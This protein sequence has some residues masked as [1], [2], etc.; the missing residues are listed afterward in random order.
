MRLLLDLA[1]ST[2][3]SRRRRA[4]CQAELLQYAK[5]VD[6]A[7][8][9]CHLPVFESH[10]VCFTPS[11]RPAGWRCTGERSE[12]CASR[13][14]V[15]HDQITLG[16]L[17]LDFVAQVGESRPHSLNGI[18]QAC[19]SI[20]PGG[21]RGLPVVSKRWRGQLV[22]ERKIA[23]GE[24]LKRNSVRGRSVLVHWASPVVLRGTRGSGSRRAILRDS[25]TRCLAGLSA[26]DFCAGCILY[27]RCAMAAA[28]ALGIQKRGLPVADPPPRRRCPNQMHL[29]PLPGLG[30][31]LTRPSTRTHNCVRA[32]RAR[33]SCAP[34][35]SDVRQ[36]QLTMRIGN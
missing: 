12:V 4:G 1:P 20:G 27:S 30:L 16:E 10:H 26:P 22:E 28:F 29:A 24:E 17:V 3:A 13:G 8:L 18:C 11:S 2:S 23:T 6:D 25:R 35:K 36:R 31:P 34:V 32:R 9:F 7:P 33:V 19:A 14:Q 5:A 15:V 21:T